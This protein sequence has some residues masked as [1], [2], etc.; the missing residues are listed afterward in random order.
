MMDKDEVVCT[1]FGVTVEHLQRAID[2]GAKTF[3][4]VKQVTQVGTGCE[5]CLGSA[6]VIVARLLEK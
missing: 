6:K 2:E 3:D 4:E 5:S 1:C